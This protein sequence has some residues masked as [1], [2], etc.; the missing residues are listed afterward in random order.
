MDIFSCRSFDAEKAIKYLLAAF[1]AKKHVKH[2]I[3]RGLDFPSK[4]PTA[5]ILS[6]V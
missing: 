4:E 2:V 1:E 5:K 6:H 3:K